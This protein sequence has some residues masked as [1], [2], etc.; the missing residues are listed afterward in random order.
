MTAGPRLQAIKP[1]DP[2]GVVAPPVGLIQVVETMIRSG[3]FSEAEMDDLA[4]HLAERRPD[5][6]SFAVGPET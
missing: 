3:R 1:E 5:R 4:R 2:D 6:W